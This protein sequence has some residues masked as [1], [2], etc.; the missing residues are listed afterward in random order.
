[1]EFHSQDKVY[2]FTVFGLKYN[3]ASWEFKD[4]GLKDKK[5]VEVAT[6]DRQQCYTQAY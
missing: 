4:K 3:A 6:V 2:Y 1:M 5:Q